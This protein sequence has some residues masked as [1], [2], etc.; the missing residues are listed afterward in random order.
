[1]CDYYY[2]WPVGLL[3]GNGAANFCYTQAGS[4]TVMVASG[5]TSDMTQ[6]F[7]SWGAVFQATFLAANGTCGTALLGTSGGDPLNASTGYYGNLMPAIAYAVDHGATDAAAAFARLTG[8]S[9]WNAVANSGF[10]DLPIWGIVP[11][12]LLGT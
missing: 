3:G 6:C 9:N 10:D 1:V 5:Q 7:A 4:Y 8:A 2:R 12:G 11:R